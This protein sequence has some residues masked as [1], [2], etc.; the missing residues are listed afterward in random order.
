M[1][2]KD[3]NFCFFF[4]NKCYEK[5]ENNNFIGNNDNRRGEMANLV[6]WHR[7]TI[8]NIA[9]LLW[10]W[11]FVLCIRSPQMFYFDWKSLSLWG[12]TT[13]SLS[14]CEVFN[15]FENFR[16]SFKYMCTEVNVTVIKIHIWSLVKWP[17]KRPWPAYLSMF[18]NAYVDP[19]SPVPLRPLT[20]VI[21]PP[22]LRQ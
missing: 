17:F 2:L 6:K 10:K 20:S 19:P 9:K 8:L 21:G 1:I 13:Y 14:W 7:I 15:L 3:H 11:P 5:R 4:F 18:I 22:E 12:V 16:C